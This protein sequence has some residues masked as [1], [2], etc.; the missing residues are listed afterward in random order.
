MP[1]TPDEM[2][3]EKHQENLELKALNYILYPVFREKLLLSSKPSLRNPLVLIP[4][5]GNT[6]EPKPQ[7]EGNEKTGIFMQFHRSEEELRRLLKE[8]E[9]CQ[10]MGWDEDF[11]GSA[12]GQLRKDLS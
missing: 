8:G 1:L 12:Q 9:K 2:A 4:Y 11:Q 10:W 7:L 6:Q 5:Q 3:S